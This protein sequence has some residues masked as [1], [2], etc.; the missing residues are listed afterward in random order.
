MVRAITALAVLLA[1]PLA[2]ADIRIT[3]WN[4]EHLG[5][6]GRGFGGGFGGGTLPL[7]TNA[8]LDEIGE[9]IRDTLQSDVIAV[10]EIAKTGPGHTSLELD[11]ITVHMGTNWEYFLADAP[12]TA[13]MVNGFIWNTDTVTALG[14]FTIDMPNIELA[15]KN[16]FDRMPVGLYLELNEPGQ[17]D[18][19]DIVL[20]NVHLAS[21]QGND[22]N[23]A[24]AMIAIEHALNR[25]LRDN[26]I[27]E[28][29][30][31]ILGDYNDNPHALT[32][33]GSLVHIQTLY[34][35]MGRKRSVDMVPA[36]MEFT[37]MNDNLTSLID[38]ILANSSAR[39]DILESE[40][41]R[42]TPGA[43][44]T[45]A[46]WRGT[47]SDHFPLSFTLESKTDFDVDF[48]P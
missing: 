23:H 48:T 41:E 21:G 6:T 33:A 14:Q 18:R 10:Q 20:I 35:H 9:F 4:I 44:S 43:P 32:N 15:G 31:V 25:T 11:R 34:Q 5:S 27:T 39:N 7:R 24:I 47:F 45:F 22:E 28:S 13:D 42:F 26:Q 37:R 40:A 2:L 8:Q 16:L 36:S 12:A 38:H 3:T 46:T 19:T 29:D 1:C 17:T 30:R